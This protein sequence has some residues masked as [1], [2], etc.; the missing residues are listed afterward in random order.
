MKEAELPNSRADLGRKKA[1]FLES[2]WVNF[3]AS[4]EE[5]RVHK[6]IREQV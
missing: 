4:L 5:G 1:A 3:G 2:L 6:V